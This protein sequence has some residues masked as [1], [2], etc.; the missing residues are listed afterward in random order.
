VG[1]G[2]PCGSVNL[3]LRSFY[4]FFKPQNRQEMNN[5]IIKVA[6][7]DDHIVVRQ[8]IV[9]LL[10]RHPAIR[11]V[12]E[13][14]DGKELLECL[15]HLESLPDIAI[16]DINMP[17]MDGYATA[18]GIRKKYPS[19]R[20]IACSLHS[21]EFCIIKMIKSGAVGFLDKGRHAIEDM[22]K[23]IDCVVKQGYYYSDS[24]GEDFFDKA[25]GFVLP[26]LTEKERQFLS[27]CCEG[28]SNRKIADKM[29]VSHRTVEHYYDSLRRK[30]GVDTRVGLVVF[31]LKRGLV[32]FT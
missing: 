22:Y 9:A 31:A 14:A 13:A 30:L 4:V 12:A 5:Q 25:S 29:F 16:L 19:V 11:V 15:Q 2:E 8:G 24:V 1:S 20:T 6:Y 28:L 26:E 23:A 17:V 18:A 7:A 10:N 21:D 32:A 27:L 3:Q